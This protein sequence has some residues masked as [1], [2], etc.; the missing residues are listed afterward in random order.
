MNSLDIFLVCLL[1]RDL[2]VDRGTACFTLLGKPV[3]FLK[4]RDGVAKAT[5][6]LRRQIEEKG[7]KE[8]LCVTREVSQQ[9]L[10]EL[11]GPIAGEARRDLAI[12]GSSVFACI[13]CYWD[14]VSDIEIEIM[15][16]SAK[17]K[18]EARAACKKQR[19]ANP[20]VFGDISYT[21]VCDPEP[22]P[23]PAPM[24]LSKERAILY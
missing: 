14:A 13:V 18:D 21:D 4:G 10:R 20:G 19:T 17:N 3:P 22:I 12:A 7:W 8:T 23:I 9:D 1:A 11:H 24:F 16:V 5:A 2:K 15:L 6:E